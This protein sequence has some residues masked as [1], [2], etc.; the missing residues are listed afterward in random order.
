MELSLLLSVSRLT[1]IYWGA[2]D[3][4]DMGCV[5]HACCEQNCCGDRTVYDE[6]TA[7]C[8]AQGMEGQTAGAMLAPKGKIA[9]DM[10]YPNEGQ[11]ASAIPAPNQGIITDPGNIEIGDGSLE[12]ICLENSDCES[13]NCNYGMGYDGTGHCACHP[14]TNAGCA[15]EY[16]CYKNLEESQGIAD[17]ASGCYLPY[18]AMCIPG[19]F[20]CVTGV[21][22][23]ITK[24]CACN[25]FMN[26]P[27]KTSDGEVCVFNED[28]LYVCAVA[29]P[30]VVGTKG[31]SK[32]GMLAT[33]S[34]PVL[35]GPP[36]TVD[37]PQ[38]KGKIMCTMDYAPVDCGGCTYSNE[39]Q[40]TATNK[41]FTLASN[42]CKPVK[43]KLLTV[44]G[45]P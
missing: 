26:Y 3:G 18:N 19:D 25:S 38:P 1:R 32:L 29:N 41:E 23:K 6:V 9:A 7:L 44:L 14:K 17:A 37:C 31:S 16:K 20:T 40:A 33:A 15:G 43:P 11:I 28:N 36:E 45:E 12:S 30:K 10:A 24:N 21:C 42:M 4:F 13:D 27:C 39:C 8:L 2:L 35:L 5:L 22:D 34:E